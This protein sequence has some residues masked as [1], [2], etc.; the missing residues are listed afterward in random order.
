MTII[1]TYKDIQLIKEKESYFDTYSNFIITVS[2]IKKYPVIYNTNSYISN[3]IRSLKLFY[4]YLEIDNFKLS[5]FRLMDPKNYLKGI[6]EKKDIYEFIND[7][8][9]FINTSLKEQFIKGII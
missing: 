3:R 4:Y 8:D 6:V 7:I 1:A 2:Y 5:Y 9:I